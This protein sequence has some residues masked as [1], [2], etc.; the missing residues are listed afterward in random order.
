MAAA[1]MNAPRPLHQRLI[2]SVGVVAAVLLAAGAILDTISN[3]N[4]LI[5]E[6]V[7][8]VG[9]AILLLGVTVAHFAL[10]SAPL[11]WVVKGNL[12]RIT[13]LGATSFAVALGLI[14]LLWLPRA[15]ERMRPPDRAA[16]NWIDLL[17][18]GKKLSVDIGD[19]PEHARGSLLV[20]G[21]S[22]AVWYQQVPCLWQSYGPAQLPAWMDGALVD[23]H[24][25]KAGTAIGRD[26]HLNR[27]DSATATS[28]CNSPRD[29]KMVVLG[30][31]VD[32]DRRGYITFG[33]SEHRIGALRAP[34]RWMWPWSRQ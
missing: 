9:S 2:A 12:T 19:L 33:G 20:E 28:E 16:T 34:N 25:N 22:Y 24:Y 1:S 10:R 4:A 26:A 13:G 18:S 31:P 7:T 32:I 8:Y 5:S 30:L 14:G 27:T 23:H 11:T 6:P 17:W 21:R 3:A 29:R 15:A